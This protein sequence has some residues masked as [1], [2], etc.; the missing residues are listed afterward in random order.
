[1][2]NSEPKNESSLIKTEIA[3]IVELFLSKDRDKKRYLSVEEYLESHGID[4][5]MISVS[6]RETGDAIAALD[7]DNLAFSQ[8]SEGVSNRANNERSNELKPG[9]SGIAI[10]FAVAYLNSA[11]AGLIRAVKKGDEPDSLDKS[12]FSDSINSDNIN[13]SILTSISISDGI[14]DELSKTLI[15]ASMTFAFSPSGQQPK[16]ADETSSAFDVDIDVSL[17]N[18]LIKQIDNTLNEISA[19]DADIQSERFEGKQLTTET[20]AVL[21]SL[22]R[23]IEELCGTNF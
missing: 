17:I 18:K 5:S 10:I 2:S 19:I 13:F 16:E 3:R 12:N 4:S 9:R 8:N 14:S 11:L 6:V 23:E 1:M 7:T 15:P 22:E 21:D 20:I